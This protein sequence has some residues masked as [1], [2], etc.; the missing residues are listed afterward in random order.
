[1]KINCLIIEDDLIYRETILGFA[2]KIPSLNV[3]ASCASAIEANVYLTA[4]NISLLFSD[5]EMADLSGLDFIRSL[6]NPPF[7]IFITSYPNYAVEGF[8]VDA[9]DFLVKPVTFDRFLKAVNKAISRIQATGPSGDHPVQTK[10]DHF[11]I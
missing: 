4:G 3:V 8:Q 10:D 2:K 11:F 7:T 1:M 5:I 9:V 6:K